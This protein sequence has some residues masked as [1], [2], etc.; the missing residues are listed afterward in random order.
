[1]NVECGHVQKDLSSTEA[2]QRRGRSIWVL[3]RSRRFVCWLVGSDPENEVLP[4][5]EDLLHVEG[6]Q[7]SGSPLRDLQTGLY[8]QK[9][10]GRHGEG[11]RVSSCLAAEPF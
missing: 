10:V 6:R 5:K 2:S 11:A 7:N 4:N 1:M 9:V 8:Y 3:R